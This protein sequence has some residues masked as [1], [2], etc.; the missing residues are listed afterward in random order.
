MCEHW[1][2][3][4]KEQRRTE[5]DLSPEEG[6]D[7]SVRHLL[8]DKFLRQMLSK[9]RKGKGTG[10][11]ETPVEFY[12]TV[13]EAATDL[14]ELVRDIFDEEYVPF[15]MVCSVFCMFW[16]GAKKGTVDEHAAYRPIGLMRHALK[17]VE[18]VLLHFLHE[19]TATFQPESQGGFR[20]SRGCRD[21]LLRLRLI[22]DRCLQLGQSAVICLL[23]FRGAFDTV[24]HRRLDAALKQAGATRKTRAIFRAILKSAQEERRIDQAGPG[25]ACGGA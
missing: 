2:E 22:I 16:K 20:W 24:S 1:S 14:F 23:D 8:T 19:E 11:D 21:H 3:T 4:D 18:V 13:E 7:T 12:L 15:E 10:D 9:L 25:P 6:E 5:D 17:L